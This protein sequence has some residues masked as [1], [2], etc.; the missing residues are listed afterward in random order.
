MKN[1]LKIWLAIG[2]VLVMAI[3]VTGCTTTTGPAL[4]ME[5]KYVSTTTIAGTPAVKINAT[6]DNHHAGTIKVSSSNF[7]LMGSDGTSHK[8]VATS[9]GL[10]SADIV[11]DNGEGSWTLMSFYLTPGTHPQELTYFDGT[12]KVTCNVEM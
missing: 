11:I 7:L 3:A 12:N 9:A 6:I 1:N 2:L 4:T 8:S 10:S 5:A